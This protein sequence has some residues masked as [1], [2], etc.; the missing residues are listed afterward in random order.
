MLA[1]RHS[2]FSFLASFRMAVFALHG[3]MRFQA[4]YTPFLSLGPHRCV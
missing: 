3:F 4:G 2:H 1:Y